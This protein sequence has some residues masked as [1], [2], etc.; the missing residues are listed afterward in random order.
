MSLDA[1]S[2]KC[3]VDSVESLGFYKCEGSQINCMRSAQLMGQ[4]KKKKKKKL[5]VLFGSCCF[6]NCKWEG[7]L[8]PCMFCLVVF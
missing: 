3:G 4:Q 1:V 5:H 8:I 2:L 6:F 7:S